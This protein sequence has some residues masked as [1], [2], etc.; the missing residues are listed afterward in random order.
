[1]RRRAPATLVLTLLL[2]ACATSPLGRKQ[3]ALMPESEMRQMGLQAFA[4]IKKETPIDHDAQAN[5]YVD[6][7]ANAITREVGGNWEVVV[8]R[9]DAANAFALP[10]GKI[11]VN[12]GMLKVARNQDQLATVLGHEVAH[13]LAEH[14]NERVSQQFA[15]ESGLALVQALGNPRSATGSTMMG[16]LGVGAQYGILLPY[17]RIQESEADLYGLDIMARAGFDPQQSIDLWVN[18]EKAGAQGPPEFLSTHPSH[19]TRIRDLK[20]RIPHALE[21]RRQAQARGK[22]PLCKPG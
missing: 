18:M 6:C 4:S 1:V 2:V 20:A 19:N 14:S 21:L 16:L 13:V 8:F 7:V 11:G 15:V 17:S 3:L 5:A 10:G 12:T 9:D 22:K